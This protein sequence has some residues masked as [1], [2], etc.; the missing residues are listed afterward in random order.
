MPEVRAHFAEEIGDLDQIELH[1]MRNEILLGANGDY[2][3]LL[4]DDLTR[5]WM[6][7]RALRRKAAT[8]TR[9]GGGSKP[10]VKTSP[11]DLTDIA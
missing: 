5:L 8:P 6:V 1:A 9:G 10:R 2:K 7:T 3:N 11:D 4:D